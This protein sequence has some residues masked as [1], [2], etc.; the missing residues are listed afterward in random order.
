M[1]K[2]AATD[3]NDRTP[4]SS[5]Q[6]V[7]RLET[8]IG[9]IQQ[10]ID[11]LAETQPDNNIV[12]QLQDAVDDHVKELN[13]L[14]AGFETPEEKERKRSLVVIG[15]PE[16]EHALASGRVK[17]DAES[18]SAML[19][20]LNVEAVPVAVYRMGRPP[21]NN[22]NNKGPRLLKVVLPSSQMQHLAFGALK[23][24]RQAVRNLPGCNRVLIRPSMTPE[25]R[26]KDREL[27]ERL[28]KK[29]AENPGV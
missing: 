12:K 25:E 2:R 13:T 24:K 22:D 17:T 4:S 8:G 6:K 21:Q 1:N 14:L 19:D 28:K 23:T 27:Q 29:R 7:S 5:R 15:L 3:N 11:R 26:E 20:V 9:N 10:L 16:P 18:V